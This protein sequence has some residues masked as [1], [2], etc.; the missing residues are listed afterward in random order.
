MPIPFELLPKKDPVKCV[1]LL[2][3]CLFPPRQRLSFI[4]ASHLHMFL[5]GVGHNALWNGF[6]FRLCIVYASGLIRVR[7]YGQASNVL[8]S[9]IFLR[10]APTASLREPLLP[11]Y[12]N[13]SR[14]LWNH[15][16]K[17]RNI[18]MGKSSGAKDAFP[19]RGT[20]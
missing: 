18:L 8:L 9:T 13:L 11:A 14:H 20:S 1:F 12:G 19:A 17:G 10:D 2:L 4:V 6:H 7:I 5:L 15:T 3:A 16:Q